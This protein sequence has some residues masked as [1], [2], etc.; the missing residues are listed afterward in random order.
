LDTTWRAAIWSQFG[1]AIETLDHLV[2]ACPDELWRS[3]LWR[4]DLPEAER[5]EFWYIAY[6]ALF[7]LDLYLYGSE[8]GFAPPAPF[9]LIEM[10]RPWLRPEPSYTK[11]QIGTYLRHGRDKCRAT[12]AALTDEKARQV[13][14]FSWGEVTFLELLLYNMRHVQEHAAQL[15]LFLGQKGLSIPDYVTQAD[16]SIRGQ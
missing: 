8:E 5:W 16:S 7:W 4:D 6:H 13:C 15:S 3:R 10:D 1:A 12:I 11:D 9:A 14:T 2:L